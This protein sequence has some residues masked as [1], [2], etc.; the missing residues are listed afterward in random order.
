MTSDA[1]SALSQR[2]DNMTADYKDGDAK[3]NASITERWSS[4]ASADEAIVS[5]AGSAG[6]QDKISTTT[7]GAANI[8]QESA[9]VTG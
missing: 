4:G 3:T 1:D 7:S 2:I 5:A 6:R 9:R 8:T